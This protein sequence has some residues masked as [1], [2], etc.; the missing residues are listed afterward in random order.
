MSPV[1][2]GPGVGGGV[3]KST[4]ALIALAVVVVAVLACWR[5]MVTSDVWQQRNPT[6]GT[7]TCQ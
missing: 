5:L 7:Q 1:L 4:E 6:E 2:A 3:K